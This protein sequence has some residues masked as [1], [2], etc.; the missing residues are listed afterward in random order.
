MSRV[1][2]LGEIAVLCR[3]LTRKKG[4]GRKFAAVGLF[5][6]RRTQARVIP[7]SPALQRVRPLVSLTGTASCAVTPAFISH[8]PISK[9]QQPDH[10]T[11]VSFDH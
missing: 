3:N 1:G 5:E 4:R 2:M 7:A 10:D 11:T 8:S 6:D 9:L